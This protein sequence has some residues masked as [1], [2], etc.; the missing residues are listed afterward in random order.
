M[1]INEIIRVTYKCNWKC[2]FCNVLQ[3]NNYWEKDVSNKEIIYQILQLLKKY[4]WKERSNLIL[5]FSWW[6]PTLNK[7]LVHYIALAKSIG[8]WKVEIQTN[9]TILFKKKSLILD[10]IHAW[11]DEI[12]LAQHSSNKNINTELWILYT[13]EDFV[14]WISYI[15]INNLDKKIWIYL[16]IVITKVN[17]PYILEHVIFLKNNWFMDFIREYNFS[18]WW[19]KSKMKKISFWFVQANW[20]AVKNKEL[21]L[22]HFS[23]Y[24]INLIKDIIAFCEKNNFFPDFHYT[25]P[26]LCIL[27]Y[28]EYNLEYQN[29]KKLKNDTMNNKVNFSSLDSYKKLWWEKKKFEECQKCKYNDYCLGFY[30]EQILFSKEEVIQNIIHTF[31]IS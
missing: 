19:K 28:P 16:N 6:E 25:S 7:N 18:V 31:V 8:I 22:L 2:K 15:K 13:I 11:L 5:S 9:W 4:S 17:L 20:Y 23:S 12:F 24:Q 21:V 10:Y 29:L 26:P 1:Y 3:T 14:E 27:N 30:K